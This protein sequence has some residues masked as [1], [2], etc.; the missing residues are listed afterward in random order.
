VKKGKCKIKAI[1]PVHLYGHPCD[2]K[3]IIDIAKKYNLKVIEDCAQAFSSEYKGKKVGSFGEAGCF[4]FFPAKNLGCYGDGGMVITN[5]K[6]IAER[7][8][9][10]RVHGCKKKNYQILHG[11]N[12]RLDTIQAAILK[13]KLKYIDNWIEKRI[14][15][16]K[17]YTRLLSRIDE[18]IPPYISQDVKHSFNYYTIRIKNGKKVRDSLMRYLIENGISCG[19]YYPV[20]QHL[21]KTNRYLG[22]KKGDFPISEKIQEEILTLPMFPELEKKEIEF[23]VEKIEEFFKKKIK[24]A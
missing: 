21:Q 11:F 1:V 18:V 23:I 19:I 20:P 2:M 7:L 16:A 8:R 15:N 3:R 6:K 24:N 17:I 5:N 13:V 9:I 4:S 22:Y 10:L 12:S 14:K